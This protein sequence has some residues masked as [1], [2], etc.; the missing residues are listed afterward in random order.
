MNGNSEREPIVST[1]KEL[2]EALPEVYQNIYGHSEFDEDSSRNC[3]LRKKY[4]LRIISAY[5]KYSKKKE[6]KVL[7]LGCAQG[8][9]SFSAAEIGCKVDAVDYLDKNID[10]CKALRDENKLDC[11]FK[12]DKISMEMIDSIEDGAY[13][14]IMF[15]SVVHHISNEHGL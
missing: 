11:T 14:I 1:I 2:V 12:E 13:D 3:E 9:Y 8:Y 7:D 6:L 4:I 15:F 10:L 5:Q